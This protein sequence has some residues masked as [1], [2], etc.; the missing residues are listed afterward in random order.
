MLRTTSLLSGLVLIAIA[1]VA[2]PKA[3]A[4]TAWLGLVAGP[5]AGSE[6]VQ[7][8]DIASLFE[9]DQAFRVVPMLGDMGAGNLR[10]LLN[11][12][13]VDIAFVSTDA[14]AAAAAPGARL[15]DHLELVARLAPQEVHVLALMEIGSLS[16]L[17]GKKVSSGRK[18]AAQLPPQPPCSRRSASRSSLSTSMQA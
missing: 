3:K 4:E 1:A 17:A 10:L 7:A 16:E 11:D 18:A 5:P 9:K 8:A 12:P 15:S 14:L 13:G 2:A 6:A